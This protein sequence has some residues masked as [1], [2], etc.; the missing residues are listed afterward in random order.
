[1]GC[2][3]D[4]R[5]RHLMRLID[6]ELGPEEAAAGAH[7]RVGS[8]WAAA[9]EDLEHSWPERPWTVTALA[10]RRAAIQDALP[11]MTPQARPVLRFSGAIMLGLLATGLM[12]VFLLAGEVRDVLP[13]GLL[14]PLALGI[15]LLLMIFAR[16]LCGIEHSLLQRL[17]RQPVPLPGG[18]VGLL[19]TCALLVVIG[20]AWLYLLRLL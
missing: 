13:L 20:G 2:V 11:A 1:M 9:L 4:L 8:A 3:M 16:Q 7:M 5:E 18:E 15:G 6:G 10:Q 14:A 12:L 19:R 17:L